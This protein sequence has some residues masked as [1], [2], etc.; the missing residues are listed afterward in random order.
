MEIMDGMILV[1]FELQLP[2]FARDRKRESDFEN[3]FWFLTFKRI[4]VTTKMKL[5]FSTKQIYFF[6]QFRVE[7][8]PPAS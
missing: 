3:Y 7:N 1:I 4:K 8:I 6:I 2:S 5:K